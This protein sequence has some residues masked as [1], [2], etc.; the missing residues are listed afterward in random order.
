MEIIIVTGS[1]CTGKT[2]YAKSLAQ[3]KGYTYIDVNR[4][5]EENKIQVDAEYNAEDRCYEVDTDKLNQI[6][7]GRIEQA[8]EKDESLVIDSHLSHYLPP[9]YADRCIV[10]RCPDLKEL[11]RRLEERGYPQK[12]VEENLEAEIMESCLQDAVAFGHEV[13]IVDTAKKDKR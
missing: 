2:T 13:E 1:V 4:I 12:K 5:I 6:L 8:R 7:I 11:R 9:E 10:M 3:E